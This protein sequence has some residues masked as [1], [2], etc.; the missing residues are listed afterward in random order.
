MKTVVACVLSFA[1]SCT[2]AA[3]ASAETVTNVQAT[4]PAPAFKI[5]ATDSGYNAPATLLPASGTSSSRTMARGSTK[6][7]W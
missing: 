6:P 2:F 1:C 5:I 4:A 3:T 7:C